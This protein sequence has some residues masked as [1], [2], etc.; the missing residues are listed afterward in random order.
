MRNIPLLASCLKKVLL[1]LQA[2][3]HEKKHL[4]SKHAALH[5][6]AYFY[7]MVVFGVPFGFDF[8]PYDPTTSPPSPHDPAASP[9]PCQG[10]GSPRSDRRRPEPDLPRVTG[11]RRQVDARAEI[12]LQPLV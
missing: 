5:A 7:L 6:A 1:V 2:E 9:G 11:Q 3:A 10:R 12:D 4:L 8:D